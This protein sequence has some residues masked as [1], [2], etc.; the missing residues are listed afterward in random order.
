[1]R[2]P[3][4]ERQQMEMRRRE[5]LRQV[6]LEQLRAQALQDR[7]QLSRRLMLLLSDLMISGGTQL[8]QRAQAPK[9][10]PSGDVG[11]WL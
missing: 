5:L 8:R 2:H 9:L 7:P 4:I 10:N 1:M 3:E 6:R 11:N